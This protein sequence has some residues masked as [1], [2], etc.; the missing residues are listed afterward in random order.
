MEGLPFV[1]STCKR[2]I[3]KTI[4]F[5]EKQIRNMEENITSLANQEYKKQMELLTSIKGIGVTLAATLI[6]VTGGFTY[7]DNTEQ[8]TR[9]LG[10]KHSDKYIFYTLRF[11]C[12]FAAANTIKPQLL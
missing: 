12:S 8:F 2:T 10:C 1:D 4:E 7:F 6:I 11:D 3:E 9:Y 5:L